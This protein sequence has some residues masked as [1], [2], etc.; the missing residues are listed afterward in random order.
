[1][2]SLIFL[3]SLCQ[4]CNYVTARVRHLQEFQN[5]FHIRQK[6]SWPIGHTS[7]CLNHSFIWKPCDY[8]VTSWISKWIPFKTETPT[9]CW[10]HLFLSKP[11][12]HMSSM[13][14]MSTVETKIWGPWKKQNLLNNIFTFNLIFSLFNTICYQ[15]LFIVFV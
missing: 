4:S 15:V 9:A 11:L 10:T 14:T 1:M 6:L 7:S 8:H 12:L 3:W 2:Y 5:G 13:A